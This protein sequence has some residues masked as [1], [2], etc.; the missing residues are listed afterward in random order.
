MN[1]GGG[2]KYLA[3]YAESTKEKVDDITNV[4]NASPIEEKILLNAQVV[5]VTHLTTQKTC[6]CCGSQVE[7]NVNES[8]LMR[9]SLANCM[10]L[11]KNRNLY[12]SH[13]GEIDVHL[14]LIVRN[15]DFSGQHVDGTSPNH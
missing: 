12:Q 14:R 1:G 5:A 13:I 8:T 10:M 11:Q 7:E 6:I 3:M 2:G 4:A 9:C 15:L